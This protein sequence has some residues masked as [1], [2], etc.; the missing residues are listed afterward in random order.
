METTKYPSSEWLN[1]PSYIHIMEDDL[2][3]K[4]NKLFRE[5]TTWMSLQGKLLKEANPEGLLLHNPLS[6]ASLNADITEVENKLVIVRGY[7][8]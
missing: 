7:G 4:K 8:W 1:R 6:G 5:T 3:A 2:A